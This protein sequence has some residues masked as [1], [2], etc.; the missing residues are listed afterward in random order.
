M[1]IIRS[2]TEQSELR[3]LIWSFPL[4]WDYAHQEWVEYSLLHRQE[5]KSSLT[6]FNGLGF[7]QV[8]A[9]VTISEKVKCL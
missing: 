1:Q 7:F 2:L 6:P 4:R 9:I 5:E 3:S 8:E